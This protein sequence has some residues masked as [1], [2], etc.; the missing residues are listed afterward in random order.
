MTG[1]T[2]VCVTIFQ[3]E[4]NNSRQ[5]AEPTQRGMP[6]RKQVLMMVAVG[7]ATISLAWNTT[8][9]GANEAEATKGE[10]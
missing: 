4:R 9:R 5:Y 8:A 6:V 3:S 7:M 10:D 2:Q 1:Y